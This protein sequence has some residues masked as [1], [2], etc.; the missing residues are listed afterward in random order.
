MNKTVNLNADLGEGCGD[1]QAMLEVVASANIA[2][3]FHA[4]DAMEMTFLISKEKYP[5]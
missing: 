1:D 3:G 4:G 2:C 5:S